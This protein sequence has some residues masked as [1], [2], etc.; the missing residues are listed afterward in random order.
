MTTLHH[1]LIE[2]YPIGAP[3]PGWSETMKM[4]REEGAAEERKMLEDEQFVKEEEKKK[5]RA[6]ERLLRRKYYGKLGEAYC[7]ACRKLNDPDVVLS[8]FKI[9]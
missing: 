9:Y 2:T 4:I 8:L 3:P 1:L 6:E 7:E 5:R